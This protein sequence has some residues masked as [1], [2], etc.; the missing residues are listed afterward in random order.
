MKQDLKTKSK[1]LSLLLRH[2]PEEADINL[3]S[4]GWANVKDLIHHAGFTKDELK[5]IVD[6]DD[7]HRYT[8]NKDGSK[9]RANQ[10]HSLDY[11]KI[12][13]KKVK[14][15]VFLYHG[16]VQKYVDN[17]MKT[18]L[19]KQS[20]NYLHLSSDKETA[21]LVGARRGKPVILTI[22]SGQM[23]DDGFTFYISKNKIYLIE[24]V[25]PKYILIDYNVN[26]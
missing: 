4:E 18:G 1:Y 19:N 15:P 12:N 2:K 21:L 22:K 8:F 10:G 7:K 13:F 25:P 11:I 20:R 5:I 16:T 26:D 23:Y 24:C 14:P 17:I 6:T 3:D 9:I